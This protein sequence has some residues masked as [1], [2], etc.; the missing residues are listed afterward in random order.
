MQNFLKIIRD[1]SASINDSSR[2]D[3][4]ADREY[5]QNLHCEKMLFVGP[6][7][8]TKVF[9]IEETRLTINVP[10]EKVDCSNEFGEYY[11]LVYLSCQGMCLKILS[12]L[13][14]P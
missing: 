12:V 6:Q 14:F 5:L 1:V 2:R 4:C 10:T 3:L 13:F 9:G 7:Y 8:V 11:V